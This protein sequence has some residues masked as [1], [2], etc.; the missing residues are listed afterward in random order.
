MHIYHCFNKRKTE[1]RGIV[2]VS[3]KYSAAGWA[4]SS[5]E[6]M[7]PVLRPAMQ[8][9]MEMSSFMRG[10]VENCVGDVHFF[11]SEIATATLLQPDLRLYGCM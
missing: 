7:P 10:K 4:P 2:M 8:V 3:R 6:K 5:P 1:V 9:I 11:D